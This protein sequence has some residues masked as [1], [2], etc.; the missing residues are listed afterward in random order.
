MW[1]DRGKDRREIE[2]KDGVRE[3][4]LECS[5]WGRGGE[6]EMVGRMR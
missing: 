1:V 2:G 3:V 6:V 5:S 4:E